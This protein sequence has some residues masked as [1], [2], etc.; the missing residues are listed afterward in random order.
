MYLS[1]PWPRYNEQI[2]WHLVWF[3]KTC[4]KRLTLARASFVFRYAPPSSTCFIFQIQ[5]QV[6][7]IIPM[8]ANTSLLELV[9]W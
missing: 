2:F 7:Y 8:H 4:Y 9:P 1:S 6:L 5:I 3:T